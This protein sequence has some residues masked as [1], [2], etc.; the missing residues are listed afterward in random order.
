MIIA[1]PCSVEGE[2]FIEIAKRV[3]ELGATHLRGGLFKPR[4]SPHRFSGLG[5]D[6]IEFVREAKR[7][8]GLPFVSEAMSAKQI[9]QLYDIVDVYQVGTRNQTASELLREFG[10]QDKPVILKRGMATTIEE[11]VM[12]ADYI[13]VEGNEKVILCE[14]G[15]RTFENYTRNTFDLS[16]IPAVKA[17]CDLPI[18]ADPSHAT[19]RRELVVPVAKGAISAGADGLLIEVHDNPEIA[20]TDSAQSITYDQFEELMTWLRL[21]TH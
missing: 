20:L 8:T 10:R 9:E 14:R 6:G 1:G 5:M 4:S 19:G 3:K 18:I 12:Y 2:N 17:L 13:M 16:C 15:I 11:F 7:V 21:Q